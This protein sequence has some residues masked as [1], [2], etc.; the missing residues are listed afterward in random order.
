MSKRILRLI[1]SVLVAAIAGIILILLDVFTI[2]SE[3]NLWISIGCSLI[4]TAAFGIIQIFVLED[5]QKS[6]LEKWGVSKIYKLRSQKSEDSDPKISKIKSNL[7]VVSFGL[8]RF[9]ETHRKDILKCLKN[10][11]VIRILTMHPDS[12]FVSQREI[13]EESAEGHIQNSIRHLIE[14][15]NDLNKQVEKSNGGYIEI[16]G[17]DCM[18]LDFYWR[19][20]NELYYGPYWFKRDSQA[21][22]TYK[23]ESGGDCFNLYTQYFE[24]LWESFSENVLVSPQQRKRK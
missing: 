12:N 7:D 18:T 4:A 1:I 17:Y 24:D 6:E 20:D 16:R 23:C 15:A 11:T 8:K 9:R 21:T 14:W 13:E 2:K 10:G 19:M 3:E 5:K 22:I